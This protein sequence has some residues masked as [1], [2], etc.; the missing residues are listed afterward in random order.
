MVR[1]LSAD[2]RGVHVELDCSSL[3]VGTPS[4]FD[5]IVKQ[6]L[7]I[8]H[9]DTLDAV[10]APERVRQLLERAAENRGVRERLRV[11]LRAI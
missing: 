9:A 8:R 4:F 6:V 3:L 7:V 2:L 10:A 1:G 5:E 11:A